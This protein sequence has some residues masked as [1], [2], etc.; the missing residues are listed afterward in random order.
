MKQKWNQ[1]WKWIITGAIATASLVP[2]A[3]VSL[4]ACNQT[5]TN[6]YVNVSTANEL[7]N[8]L[9]DDNLSV[10]NNIKYNKSMATDIVSQ[11]SQY[12]NQLF[13]STLTK[14]AY[15]IVPQS[16]NG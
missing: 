16:L 10:L 7:V 1:K 9:N 3:A 15:E 6:P 8:L 12:I 13:Q 4:V 11:S 2:I 14:K 5:I